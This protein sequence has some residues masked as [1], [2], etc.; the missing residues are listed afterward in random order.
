MLRVQTEFEP[1][2]QRLGLTS[3]ESVVRHFMRGASAAET[4]TIR[5]AMLAMPDGLTMKVFWKLYNY[6]PPAWKFIGRPSKAHCEFKNYEVFARLGI[7]SATPVA[8][9]EQRDSL[10]RLRRA[11]ILTC[12]IP[13]ALTLK[14]F[15][16]QH[17]VRRGDASGRRNRNALLRQLADM[18]W[19]IH[20]AGFFHHD[21]VWRNI[22][23]TPSPSAGPRVWWI[24]CP[25]GRFDRWSP[26]RRRRRLKDLASLDKVASQL[27]TRSER[28]NFIKLYLRKTRLDT[29]AKQLIRGVL[30]Y[31]RTRWPEDG[32]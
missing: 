3:C 31:R 32:K 10:G 28:L 8:C 19:R 21:L 16:E 26:L 18:T 1:A 9:G 20:E 24:D 5:A 13:D 23:V 30:E 12:A 27:C 15:V 7:P 4:V 25:R 29:E 6:D 11:F 17:C 2:F 22:L 14:E